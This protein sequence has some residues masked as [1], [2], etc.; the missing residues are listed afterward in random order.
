MTA[1]KCKDDAVPSLSEYDALHSMVCNPWS[2]SKCLKSFDENL[3]FMPSSYDMDSLEKYRSSSVSL[4][5]YYTLVFFSVTGLST[6][7]GLTKT[8]EVTEFDDD[9]SP[10]V[11]P[12]QLEDQQQGG[13]SNKNIDDLL[14]SKLVPDIAVDNCVFQ[15]I[16][17]R[18]AGRDGSN[19]GKFKIT[20]KRRFE[21]SF[22]IVG[23]D[24]IM[25]HV[26]SRRNDEK[27]DTAKPLLHLVEVYR[28]QNSILREIFTVPTSLYFFCSNKLIFFPDKSKRKFK[29][30]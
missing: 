25:L 26:E 22:G 9:E 12:I 5:A 4:L 15:Y 30:N 3:F 10:Q 21:Y 28:V 18:L 11:W 17:K 2:A 7:L 16:E 14:K 8:V 1:T 13:D 23:L 19:L 6:V 29:D 24:V 27:N 20:L